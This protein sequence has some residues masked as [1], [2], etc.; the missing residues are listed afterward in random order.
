MVGHFTYHGPETRF[1]QCI[2]FPC[3]NV[4][5]LRVSASGATSSIQHRSFDFGDLTS[6]N[7]REMKKPPR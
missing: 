7:G 5:F 4:P 2:H 1:C 6:I 3:L